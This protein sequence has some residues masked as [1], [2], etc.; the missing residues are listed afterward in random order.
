MQLALVPSF[1]IYNY[2]L[3]IAKIN[4]NK[5]LNNLSFKN[6]YKKLYKI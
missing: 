6:I 2:N 1:I 3:H 4:K 5:N